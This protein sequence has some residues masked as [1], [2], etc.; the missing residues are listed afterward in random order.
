[1]AD[2]RELESLR[3]ENA[4]L[5]ERLA[6]AESDA[7]RYHASANDMLEVIFPYVRPTDAELEELL[8]PDP[9]GATPASILDEYAL[10]L[11]E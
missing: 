2:E 1:M 3:Q 6:R 10:E 4:E 8:K 7:E 11:G 9:S 5:R